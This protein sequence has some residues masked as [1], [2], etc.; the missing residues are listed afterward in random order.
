MKETQAISRFKRFLQVE[1]GLSPNSIYSYTYDLKKFSEYLTSQNKDILAATQEDVQQFLKFEK[2][3]KKNSTRTLA[4]SLAAIRQF[5]NFLSDTEVNID[6]PTT[7]IE[8][9]HIEKTLPDFLTIKEVDKLFS[10]ISEEDP[11][12]LR[13]KTIFELLYSSGL[14]ISEAV[15]LEIDEMDFENSFLSIIGKGDKE[16]IVPVNEEAKR[17][18]LKYLRDS[19]QDILGTRESEYLFVSK[20][21]SKLNRKSVWRLLKNYVVRTKITKNITPH[22]LRH[23]F[24]THLIENGADLRSVQ[25]L[26]GHMDISTTQV[27][28]HLAKEKLQKIHKQYHPKG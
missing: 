12:E 17:L 15:D 14:R 10:S 28:T 5:Y 23:S 13:D 9:P 1:K 18:L 2:T 4:R 27:Y 11:Y 25:E 19:R 7:K 6:N 20:K 26:L 24:A 8:S 22:T 3:K 16:R 21:G